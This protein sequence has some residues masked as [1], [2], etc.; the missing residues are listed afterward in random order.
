MNRLHAG[1]D[2]HVISELGPKVGRSYSVHLEFATVC[3]RSHRRPHLGH[4]R[5]IRH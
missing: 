3:E 5:Q 2:H 1:H 4:P